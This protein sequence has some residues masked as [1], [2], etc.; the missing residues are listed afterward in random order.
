MNI[1][2]VSH[3]LNTVSKQLVGHTNWTW[4][5]SVEIPKDEV[6]YTIHILKEDKEEPD[7][8]KDIQD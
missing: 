4:G 7:E 1:K 3:I 6:A 5:Y 2:F 8:D